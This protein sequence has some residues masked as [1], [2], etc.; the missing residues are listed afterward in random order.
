MADPI[1]M[2]AEDHARLRAELHHLKTNARRKV[3]QDLAHA[4]SFGDFSENAELDEA[5]RD[6]ATLEGRIKQ[7]EDMLER[8]EVVE[9]AGMEHVAVGATVR[10]LDLEA[11]EEL[12]FAVGLNGAADRGAIQ[13]TPD[14]PLGKGFMGKG[15]DEE[16]EV[17]TPA[18]AR[19]YRIVEISFPR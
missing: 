17:Q 10:A 5:K 15:V 3:R 12:L 1:P 9:T 4:R 11:D 6:H 14:S 18:G 7:L 19:R 2:T 13:I 8:V 16:V